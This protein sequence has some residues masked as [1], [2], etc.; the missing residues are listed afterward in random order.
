M[1]N[2]T[3]TPLANNTSFRGHGHRQTGF[4]L[5]EVMVV[6]VILGIMA[7]MI[8]PNLTNKVGKANTQRAKTDISTLSSALDMYQ[9]ENF[10]YPSSDQGLQA[11][12]TAPSTDMP[13]YSK[14]GYLKKAGIKDPWGRDYL[15]DKPS[16]YGGEYDVYT[17]GRDG[18]PGGEEQDQDVGSWQ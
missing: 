6:I 5:L 16:Q 15:Y 17:Y 8:V 10:D 9:L 13:N 18:V 2:K 3:R 12:V 11:L 1:H 14:G 4:T 7:A